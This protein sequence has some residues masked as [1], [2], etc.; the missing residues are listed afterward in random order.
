MPEEGF[1]PCNIP[2]DDMAVCV[3]LLLTMVQSD[4]MSVHMQPG[5]MAV[6]ANP[7]RHLHQ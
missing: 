1:V 3:Q 2:P 4:V 7:S 5:A 6:H